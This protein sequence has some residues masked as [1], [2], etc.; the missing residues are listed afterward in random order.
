MPS[1]GELYHVAVGLGDEVIDIFHREIA[2]T[3]AVDVLSV[4]DCNI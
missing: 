4:T 1:I 2:V 3:P